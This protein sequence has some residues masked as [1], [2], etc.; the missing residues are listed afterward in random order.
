MTNSY[1]WPLVNR[2]SHVLLMV[3]FAAAYILGDFDDLLNYHVAFGLALGVVFLFRGIWG[4]IGP[5]YSKFKDFNFNL[6][7]LKEY[8]LSPFSKSK[9]YAGHNPA[10]SWAI[11][12][13]IIVSFLTIL[14]GLL[15]YGIEENHGILSFLHTTYFKEMELFEDIHEI[16]SNLFLAIIGAHIAGALIDRFIKKSD[17]IDSMVNGYKKLAEKVD[18]RTNIAQKLFGIIWI[19][20]SLFSLYYL[21]F[22][23]DNIF[24]ANANVK[25]NYAVLHMDFE[26]ECGSCH[27]T[28]P[29]FL[30]PKN[31]WTLMMKDLENHFGDDASIDE[32]TNLSILAF[33]TQNSAENSTHQASLK[34]LKSLKDNN[35]TIAITKTPFW[36]KKH[37]EIDKSVFLSK[38][39][40]SSAN[41]KACHQD[42]EHGL[43]END[44]IKLPEIKG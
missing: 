42:I 18:V 22:A 21:I 43:I 41:C 16:F 37:D 6:I 9:E 31:S 2:V 20:I 32:L 5:K 12:A 34:I 35:S 30:L 17:A 11:V 7:D 10:S 33:L 3:F 23:K 36:K 8:L 40:K 38:E 25:Q 4:F 39:V 44:L 1:I 29:P 13:M 26:N 14:S 24:I 19:V 28:Y 27:I 15:A